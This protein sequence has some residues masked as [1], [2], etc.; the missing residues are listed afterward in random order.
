MIE[1]HPQFL[2][3]NGKKEFAV[4]PYEEF[5]RIQ[6]LL[7]DLEDLEYLIKA[8]E[9]GKDS[10]SFSLLEVKQM[11]IQDDANLDMILEER[12]IAEH[13]SNGQKMAEALIK[14]AKHNV[15]SKINAQ[16]WRKN[17]RQDR[18]LPNRD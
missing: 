7:E 15:L 16:E 12:Q 14:I 13:Q 9:E 17:I 11:L 2:T 4:L 8:K 18:P 5:L 3:K 1:L 6:E 10:P